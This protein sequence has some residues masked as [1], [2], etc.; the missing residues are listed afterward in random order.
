MTVT[1]K[2]PRHLPYPGQSRLQ[3]LERQVDSLDVRLGPQDFPARAQGLREAEEAGISLEDHLRAARVLILTIQEVID[4]ADRLDALPGSFVESALEAAGRWEAWFPCLEADLQALGWDLLDLLHCNRLQAHPSDVAIEAAADLVRRSPLPAV[5]TAARL[6]QVTLE[7]GLS[8]PRQVSWLHLLEDRSGLVDHLGLATEVRAT[9]AMQIAL[10]METASGTM[11][12]DLQRMNTLHERLGETLGEG[13][14]VRPRSPS[15]R[16][17]TSL[18][19]EGAILTQAVMEVQGAIL[20]R[21]PFLEG[22]IALSLARIE[23]YTGEAASAARILDQLMA[24]GF[25]IWDVAIWRSRLALARDYPEDARE[26][27]ARMARELPLVRRPGDSFQAPIFRL[28]QEAG[29]PDQALGLAD[30]PVAWVEKASRNR[31][32]DLTSLLPASKREQ[33][34]RAFWNERRARFDLVLG[35][36]LDAA[37][38][39]AAL[40]DAS[41][42]REIRLDPNEA[43]RCN[44]D[45]L[46]DIPETLR[47]LL[48]RAIEAPVPARDVARTF[49]EYVRTRE[50]TGESLESLLRTFPALRASRAFALERIQR[51]DVSGNTGE[52]LALLDLYETL[53]DVPDRV[54]LDLWLASRQLVTQS[55]RRHEFLRHGRRIWA[56]LRGDAGK[57]CGEVLRQEVYSRILEPRESGSWLEMV[58]MALDT[59]PPDDFLDRLGQW[60]LDV[61]SRVLPLSTRDG[62]RIAGLLAGQPR[63]STCR[64]IRDYLKQEVVDRLD[65]VLGP[66][67]WIERRDHLERLLDWGRGDPDVE[68]RIAQWYRGAVSA[69]PSD[70]PDFPLASDTGAW[71][72]G[73]LRGDAAVAVRRTTGQHLLKALQS[74]RNVD[75]QQEVLRRIESLD[76]QDPSLQTLRQA[77]PPR[78]AL[79]RWTPA[80]LLIGA[81]ILVLGLLAFRFFGG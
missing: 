33:V 76:P 46:P 4:G 58:Q 20:N 79:R 45:R 77:I 74:A 32:R 63:S 34:L 67:S 56:R 9:L 69:M 19:K 71:L 39:D 24:K 16:E 3:E 42:V 23:A 28:W 75:Q 12:D 10:A 41:W 66:R 17:Q 31:E 29:G 65:E 57:V 13:V 11:L 14:P 8:D 38:I 47:E 27:L 37:D 81:T 50:S 22:W 60:Y 48:L 55:P 25:C 73:V 54:I 18:R 44:L 51:M 30:P 53:P 5:R 21:D 6:L 7:A 61:G 78:G 59:L 49:L 70:S 35:D 2:A 68:A 36:L 15:S 40:A 80:I 64:S 1:S 72:A 43:A 26:A 52:A 62:F